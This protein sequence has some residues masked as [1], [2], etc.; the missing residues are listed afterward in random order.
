MYTVYDKGAL[1]TIQAKL[2]LR[3]NRRSMG[4]LPT[5]DIDEKTKRELAVPVPSR[6]AISSPT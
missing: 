6:D 1:Q 5:E 2:G 4:R 3:Y